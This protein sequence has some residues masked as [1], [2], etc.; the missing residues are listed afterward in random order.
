MSS[1]RIVQTIDADTVRAGNL[2]SGRFLMSGSA[3]QA[4]DLNVY[5]FSVPIGLKYKIISITG[6]VSVNNGGAT[7]IAYASASGVALNAPGTALS[8]STALTDN[9]SV[10]AVLVAGTEALV[11]T[12]VPLQVGV[13]LNQALEATEIATFTFELE[14]IN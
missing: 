7:W 12:A 9:V 10:P 13:A 6:N 3:Q 1:N 4:T 11:G 14:P 8:T 5:I 2:S